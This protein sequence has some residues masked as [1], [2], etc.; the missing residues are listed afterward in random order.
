MPFVYSWRVAKF[1]YNDVIACWAKLHYNHTDNGT[2]FAGS[3]A[4]LCKKLGIIHHCITA[5]N[6]K[7][8]GQVQGI[9]QMLKD[10]IWNG[11]NL[12]GSFWLNHLA[13]ALSR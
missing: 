2:R 3:F 6:S 5:G 10:Y 13:L 8:Y 7:A 12:P 9:I 4:Q 11:L 1:L